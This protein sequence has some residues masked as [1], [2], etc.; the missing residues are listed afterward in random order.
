MSR[1]RGLRRSSRPLSERRAPQ[2]GLNGDALGTFDALEW[3]DFKANREKMLIMSALMARLAGGLVLPT[4][5]PD[6]VLEA[7]R[8][9]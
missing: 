1:R 5:P 6:D 2:T 3:N 8:N 9:V 7:N 4:D